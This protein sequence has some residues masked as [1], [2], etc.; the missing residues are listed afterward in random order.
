[1]VAAAAGGGEG[2]DAGAVGDGSSLVPAALSM[3]KMA[4]WEEETFGVWGLGE[5]IR[6][7]SRAP[8]RHLT[9][10]K[11]L[12]DLL[13]WFCDGSVVALDETRFEA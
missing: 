3:E 12:Y 8:R 6:N 5:S 2:L 9:C 13:D 10:S 7:L 4:R 11:T 1:M